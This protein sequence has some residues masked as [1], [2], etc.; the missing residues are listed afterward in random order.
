MT[1]EFF[2]LLPYVIGFLVLAAAAWIKS[3]FA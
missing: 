1:P 2:S 3:M